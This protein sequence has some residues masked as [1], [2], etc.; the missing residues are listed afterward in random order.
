M[1]EE[2]FAVFRAFAEI[3][4]RSENEVVVIDT[5]PTGHTL[6]LLDSTQSY[7]KEIARS[8]GDSP[9]SVENLLP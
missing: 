2:D 9:E 8:Q 5:A 7:H 6:P 3:V 1:S 4:A